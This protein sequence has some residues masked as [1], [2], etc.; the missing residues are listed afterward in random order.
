MKLKNM[1]TFEQHTSE[2]NISDV[3]PR[4]S[5]GDKVYSLTGRVRIIKKGDIGIIQKIGTGIKTT[6][7]V[8]FGLS[9][10]WMYEDELN[11][12]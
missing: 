11:M 4:F 9:C 5:I 6:Y 12:V 1:K 8:K 7:W 10:H 3:I 2:M